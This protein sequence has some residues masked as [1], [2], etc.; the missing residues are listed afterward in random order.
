MRR[1]PRPR[2]RPSAPFQVVW[3]PHGVAGEPVAGDPE[4]PEVLLR[5]MTDGDRRSPQVWL[6]IAPDGHAAR[7]QERAVVRRWDG[8]G[9]SF[10]L[11]WRGDL[12]AEEVDRL[13]A[14]T[15]RSWALP[16]AGA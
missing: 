12:T 15:P 11:S 13:V 5:L 10:A 3:W 7:V 14:S 16:E 4:V 6:G 8:D 9:W 1:P 2:E